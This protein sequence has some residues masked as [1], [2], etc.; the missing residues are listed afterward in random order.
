MRDG[1]VLVVF[2][3]A[4]MAL[5]GTSLANWTYGKHIYPFFKQCDPKWGSDKMGLANCSINTCPGATFG[6]DTVCNE[7]CAMSCISMA[8]DA[9]GYQIHGEIPNPGILNAWLVENDGYLCLDGNCNDLDLKQV[10]KID[11]YGTI[12]FLGEIFKPHFNASTLMK[13]VDTGLVVIAHVREKTH[14]VLL[15]G[16][17]DNGESY[18]VLDPFYNSTT[19]AYEDISDVIMYSMVLQ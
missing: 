6:R 2:V 1:L 5:A 18:T 8:L 3:A 17:A 11:V 12:R 10:E 9:Y 13:A 4:F 7:G 16:S 19:Y 15:N 14:F